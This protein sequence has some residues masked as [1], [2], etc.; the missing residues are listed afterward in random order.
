MRKVIKEYS[1][2]VYIAVITA[3]V[4]VILV[5]TNE[6]GQIF[7]A[8]GRLDAVW[9]WLAGGCIVLYLFLRMATLRFYLARNGHR[10]SWMD[11]AGVTGAGQFYSAI[12]PSSS[13]GQPMQVFWLRRMNVPVSLGTASVCVK[14]LG[15]QASFLAMGAVMGLAHWGALSGYMEGL[16]WLVGLGFVI[17]SGLIAAVL[18]TIPKSRAVDRMIRWLVRMGERFRLVK[19]GNRALEDFLSMLRDYREALLQ[20]LRKP[21]DAAAVLGLSLLQVAAYMAVIVCLYR[22]F[23]LAGADPAELLTVQLMLFI[24]A[25]F[26]PLPGAAGAQEGGFCVF[27]RG[28]FPETE[29]IAAMVCWRFFSYYLLM[30]MGLAMMVPAKL[31]MQKEKNLK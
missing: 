6:L 11:A 17:N 15:F 21:L 26:V 7:E 2:L 13:G 29:L 18:L 4:I 23:G 10:I 3:V 1:G 25:A 20:M 28:I 9:V 31:R 27:F 19:D 30:F 8:L 22:A 14:F 12:T 24:A 16:R 5:C